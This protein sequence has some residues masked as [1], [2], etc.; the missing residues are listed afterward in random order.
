MATKSGSLTEAGSV[1]LSKPKGEGLV[2]AHI[3]GTYGT[4]EFVFEGSIDDGTNWFPVAAIALETEAQAT[5]TV[6]PT[7][8][9]ELGYRVNAV[10][11]SNVRLRATTVTSGT[12]EVKL[13]SAPGLSPPNVFANLLNGAFGAAAFTGAVSVAGLPTFTDAGTLAAAGSAQGDAAAVADFATSVS[14]ADGTKGV[15]LPAAAAGKVYLVYNEHATSGLKVYPNTSDTINGG[16]AN[17]AVTTEGKTLALFYA[18][19]A[20]NWGAIFT[21]NS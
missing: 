11:L 18:L 12:L 8:N 4:V 15:V 13:S 19:D 14:A 5:G 21:A 2:V 20:T 17:A 16:S 9:A 1:A 6:S 10:G 7:D 3:A